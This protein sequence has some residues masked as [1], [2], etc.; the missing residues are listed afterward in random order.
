MALDATAVL[1]DRVLIQCTLTLM[2][3][4]TNDHDLPEVSLADETYHITI[5]I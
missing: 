4:T 3:V 2:I 1:T 5:L